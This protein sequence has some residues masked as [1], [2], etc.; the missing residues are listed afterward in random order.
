MKNRKWTG[1]QKLQIVLEGLQGKRPIGELC[2]AFEIS[3]G[4]YYK[5][6]DQFL[7]K[8]HQIFEVDKD[9]KTAT[10]EAKVSQLT[11]YVGELTVELKKTENELKWLEA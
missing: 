5:W 4:Q 10:L 7:K 1:T 3:Q 11:R 6:R 8:G 9:K 2:T